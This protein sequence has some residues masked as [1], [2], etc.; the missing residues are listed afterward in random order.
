MSENRVS[1]QEEWKAFNQQMNQTIK[2]ITSKKELMNRRYLTFLNSLIYFG[3]H[4]VSEAVPDA[5]QVIR[6]EY[7]ELCDEWAAYQ[8][9]IE[10]NALEIYVL[11]KNHALERMRE[12]VIQFRDSFHDL[13]V[14]FHDIMFFLNVLVIKQFHYRTITGIT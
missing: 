14:K 6:N 3:K 5:I 12:T 4:S 8:S 13:R 9:T 2:T 10:N 11:W 1:V 7:R